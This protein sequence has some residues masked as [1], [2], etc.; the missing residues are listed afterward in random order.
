MDLGKDLSDP[1]PARNIRNMQAV[2]VGSST[3]IPRL[4]PFASRFS[5]GP[6]TLYRN[7]PHI[8]TLF[9]QSTD[10]LNTI[11]SK[12]AHYF[13]EWGGDKASPE[14]YSRTMSAT[15]GRLS[16]LAPPAGVRVYA[17]NHPLAWDHGCDD[18]NDPR[19]FECNLTVSAKNENK[20]VSHRHVDGNLAIAQRVD[21]VFI[22]HYQFGKKRLHDQLD[23]FTMGEIFTAVRTLPLMYRTPGGL[24]MRRH[25]GLGLLKK[26]KRQAA[27]ERLQKRRM[28][29]SNAAG[30]SV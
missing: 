20:L 7:T 16:L 11:D 1:P 22:C 28:E 21:E 5:Q 23:N 13:D 27:K 30:S 12:S 25:T 15:V 2:H 4:R 29:R 19:C 10:V 8:S 18:S 26:K 6:F 9:L 14:Q 17:V 24:Q 3:A